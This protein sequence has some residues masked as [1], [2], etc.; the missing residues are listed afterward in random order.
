MATT[1]SP[2]TLTIG[3]TATV[4]LGGVAHDLSHAQTIASV[5]EVAHR[6][7][8]VPTSEITILKFAAT[9]PDAGSFDEADVRWIAIINR[10]D[11]NFVQLTFKSEGA[12][13]F[14]VKLDAGQAFIYGC[15]NSGGVV[16]TMDA[17]SSALTV[18]FED[19]VDITAL[20]DTAAVDLELYVA[21]V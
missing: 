2:A 20:A 10:D 6:I 9:S 21:G 5:V 3:V 15:D 13:E 11:T 1:V 18:S 16:D 4:T 19:L 7:V 17:D 14:A 8:E 12:A